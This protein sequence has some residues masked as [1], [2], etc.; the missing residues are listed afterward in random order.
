MQ[1]TSVPKPKSPYKEV[2]KGSNKNLIITT[3]VLLVFFSIVGLVGLGVYSFIKQT[4]SKVSKSEDTVSNNEYIT[5]FR[6]DIPSSCG[7]TIGR[8]TTVKQTP[9]YLEW[10]YEERFVAPESFRGLVPADISSKGVLLTAMS[11]KGEKDSWK[12]ADE[13]KTSYKYG[14][15]GLVSYCVNNPN[16]WSLNDFISNIEKISTDSLK[17]SIVGD[18]E[19]WGEFSVQPINVEGIFNG[20]YINE[21]FFLAVTSINTDFSR[22][23]IFQP[24]GS[25]EERIEIDRKALSPSLKNRD[26]NSLL[27]QTTDKVV[28]TNSPVTNNVNTNILVEEST[29]PKQ[30][31]K[32][33][34]Y[35]IYE[36]DFKSDKCYSEDDLADLRYYIQQY[37]SAVFSANAASSS[38]KF[39]CDGSEFFKDRCSEYKKQYEDAKKD[40]NK[41]E[42]IVKS[43]IAKGK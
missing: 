26:M 16:N 27:Q 12:I 13:N 22:L 14:F 39:T 5:E 36:G 42:D 1:N 40:K 19:T 8:P 34:R 10:T 6:S 3:V 38:M 18:K 20:S 4:G 23:V 33:S 41:Y 21:P 30:E 31:S 28:T 7:Y 2:Q 25:K 29:V 9:E 43:I 37:N 17:Y 32:C 24:W 11:F 35:K 15:A